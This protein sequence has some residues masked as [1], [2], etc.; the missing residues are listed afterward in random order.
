MRPS[1]L[2]QAGSQG[3]REER[4]ANF[5]WARFLEAAFAAPILKIIHFFQPRSTLT[6]GEPK[7]QLYTRTE[8]EQ[9]QYHLSEK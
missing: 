1:T 6:R 5:F 3:K 7:A 9:N 2:P 4:R 8:L